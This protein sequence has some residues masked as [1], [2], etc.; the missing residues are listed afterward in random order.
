M[1]VL[2]FVRDLIFVGF[3]LLF[4][5]TNITQSWD[6]WWVALGGTLF[7]MLPELADLLKGRNSQE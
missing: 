7:F 5:T 4:M 3:V 6:Y 1:R 2:R